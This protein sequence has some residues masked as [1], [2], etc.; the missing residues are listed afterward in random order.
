MVGIT[1]GRADNEC[2]VC[3]ALVDWRNPHYHIESI[4]TNKT[5]KGWFSAPDIIQQRVPA[6]QG[7]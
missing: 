5:E 2:P 1:V 3:G 7:R 4:S 6:D